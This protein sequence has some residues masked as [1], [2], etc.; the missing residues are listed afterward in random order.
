MF[1]Q[2]TMQIVK[3]IVSVCEA[4]TG[5]LEHYGNEYYLAAAIVELDRRVKELEAKLLDRG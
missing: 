4:S 3:Q 1:N 5:Q 2:N